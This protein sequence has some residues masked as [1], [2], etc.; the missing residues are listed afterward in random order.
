FVS[1]ALCRRY[2]ALKDERA[3]AVANCAGIELS[4]C[5]RK[6]RSPG[7]GETRCGH[8]SATSEA[9][10]ARWQHHFVA[11]CGWRSFPNGSCVASNSRLAAHPRRH[12]CFAEHSVGNNAR[13]TDAAVA[14]N[15][16]IIA[17]YV[18]QARFC[19]LVLHRLIL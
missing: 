1:P 2:A 14:I 10:T 8:H 9:T 6:Y 4:G 7:L 18:H 5:P 15:E 16:S 11:R 12:D 13:R 3:D 17:S 19:L